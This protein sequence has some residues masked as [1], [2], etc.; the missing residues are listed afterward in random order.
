L[1][2]FKDMKKT[3]YTIDAKGRAVGRVATE[4]AE[5]LRGKNTAEFAR[6]IAPAVKLT[7][8]NA[9]QAKFDENRLDVRYHKHYTGHPGGMRVTTH[10]A[11]IAK[12]GAAEL[13]RLAIHGMIPG[14]KLRP[15]I[16]KNLIIT[17]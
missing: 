5:I 1:N 7:I 4:A 12:K 9:S 3:E 13:F 15:I 2:L 10:A 17:D 6:N 8:I 14:N 11:T 16:M